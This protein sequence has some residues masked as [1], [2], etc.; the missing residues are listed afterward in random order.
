MI[1]TGIPALWGTICLALDL[2]PCQGLD[3][4]ISQPHDQ[5]LLDQQVQRLASTI[6]GVPAMELR[7]RLNFTHARSL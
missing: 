3:D 1:L 2:Q 5:M 6:E 7:Q 4:D